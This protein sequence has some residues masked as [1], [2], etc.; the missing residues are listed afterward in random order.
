MA[1]IAATLLAPASSF[2]REGETK[3]E[4]VLTPV[5]ADGAPVGRIP[6]GGT[7]TATLMGALSMSFRE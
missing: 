1:L 4:S 7:V 2:A 6:T 3:I 5:D